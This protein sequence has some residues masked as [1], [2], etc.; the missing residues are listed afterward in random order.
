MRDEIKGLIEENLNEINTEEKADS[1]HLE[2]MIANQNKKV[3]EEYKIKEFLKGLK[4]E[5][6][7]DLT[8][9]ELS[10]LQEKLK[11]E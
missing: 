6:I 9:E 8:E 2:E 4:K 10:V 1:N 3:Q 5:S 11:E 7:E